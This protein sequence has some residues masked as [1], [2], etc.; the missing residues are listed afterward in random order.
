MSLRPG[1]IAAIAVVCLW[2]GLMVKHLS[3]NYSRETAA[4]VDLT[5]PSQ[6][7]LTQRGVFY[8]G[9]R[10]GYIRE[11]VAPTPEGGFLA[12]Q[13]GQFTIKVL[14]RNRQMKIEGSANL[15]GLGKLSSFH[16]Q[17]DTSSRRTPFSTTVR[18][19]V[20]E[21][22]LTLTIENGGQ[23]RV[24]TRELSEPIVLPLNLYYSLA[25][26]GFESGSK[27]RL[28]LFDPMTLS[29]GAA[30]VEVMDPE[31]VRWGGRE[32]EAYR[33][34]TTFSGL[35]T[36]AWV[37]ESGEVL[38]EETPLGWTLTKEAPESSLNARAGE[39]APDVVTA[40][41]VPAI[42]F[43]ESAEA[44]ASVRLKLNRFP[45]EGFKGLS[46]GRQSVDPD[47]ILSIV[48]ETEPFVANEELSDRELADALEADAFIQSDAPEIV[49]MARSLSEGLDR[50]G[51]ARTIGA[52]VHENLTKSPTLSIPSAIEV[53]EQ[54]VGDCNEHTVLFTALARAAQ[55][56]T[57]I[58]TGV[59]YTNGQFYYHAWPEVHVGRWLALDPT[60]G[61]FPADPMH[62]RLLTGGLENQYE[63]LTLMGREASIEV[64]EAN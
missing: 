27:V 51:A 42:G 54:R 64:L 1:R 33:L 8:K 55:I 18:G 28:R 53:L 23:Q 29:D 6:A 50:L 26:R 12:E 16:F 9:A 59:A 19:V 21:Q 46:G 22:T 4:V 7:E 32:E 39:N 49:E 11:R 25:A 60:F 56:P 41:A 37:N 24:E 34:K 43:I 62:V 44:L 63:V 5:K 15:D 14:G 58:A 45:S 48:K 35:T 10:I 38:K 20:H 30:E 61:Q 57:R 47:G 17:L 52:W 13:Q 36:T 31:I 40:A 2:A 3:D